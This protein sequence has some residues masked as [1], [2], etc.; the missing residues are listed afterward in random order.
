MKAITTE[1]WSHGNQVW[2]EELPALLIY[3]NVI[4]NTDQFLLDWYN[5]LNIKLYLIQLFIFIFNIFY[6]LKMIKE[7]GGIFIPTLL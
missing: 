4:N 5:I 1:Y 2:R 7:D 6:S 3:A